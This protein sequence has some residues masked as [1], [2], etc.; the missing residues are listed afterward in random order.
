MYPKR[1]KK[2][3]LKSYFGDTI[4]RSMRVKRRAN[5]Q[6][7]TRIHEC[8][9]LVIS[10]KFGALPDGFYLF[11]RNLLFGTPFFYFRINIIFLSC[12]S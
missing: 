9:R 5:Y 10:K 8:P 6:V 1:F 3:T 12:H 4:V 11:F 2:T 7:Y